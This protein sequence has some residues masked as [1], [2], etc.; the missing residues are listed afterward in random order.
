MKAIGKTAT[1]H[2]P[3]AARRQCQERLGR[4]CGEVPSA[5]FAC[6]GTVDGRAFAFARNDAG[7][8]DDGKAAQRMAAI[9]CSL[10]ALSESF[11]RESIRGNC[12]HALIASD[13]GNIIVVRVPSVSR[14]YVISVGADASDMQAVTL[15]RA[16]D[17]S[18]DLASIIDGAN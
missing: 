6:L 18:Q 11:S 13:H 8:A 5:V 15:R 1:S 4:F 2:A 14:A 7:D 3:D 17:L 16:L 9:S 12:N 10:V